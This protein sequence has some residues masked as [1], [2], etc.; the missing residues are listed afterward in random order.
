MRRLFTTDQARSAGVTTAALRWGEER[1]WWR[2][3]VRGVYGDGPDEP[4]DLDVARARVVASRVVARA[5]L[6]GVLHHLDGITLDG[7][8]PRCRAALLGGVVEV[9]GVPCTGGRQT[10]IDLAACV[11]DT[12]WEQALESALRKRLTTVE[13]LE[14]ALP[15]LGRART[16]GVKRI[17]RV[18]ALR[19]AGAPPTE[20][21]LETLMV[22]LVR[23]VDGLGDPVRQHEVLDARGTFVARVDLCW[24]ELGLFLELDG[25]QHA[26]Q[27]VYDARR[28]TAVVAVT[29]WLPGRFTWREVVHV[30]RT[31]ARRL[32]E[33]A[34]QAVARNGHRS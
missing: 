1:R 27:P 25:Q 7:P 24:P 13:A 2:R 10:L 11:D 20:S 16:P 8:P 3:I 12:V 17:R 4:T 28:Q 31:T 26:G 22:Q 18:L 9:A 30:P 23:T 14:S 34:G 5:Q 21:L 15:A 6:A 32:Q 29:G 19:P 33:L